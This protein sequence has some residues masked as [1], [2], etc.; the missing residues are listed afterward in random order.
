MRK[1]LIK[2]LGL[3]GSS[4]PCAAAAQAESNPTSMGIQHALILSIDGAHALDIA[5]YVR[6]NPQSA[7]AQLGAMGVNYTNASLPLGDFYPGVL[8]LVTGGTPNSTGVWYDGGFDRAL[9]AAGSDCTKVGA[10]F[11]YDENI[12]INVGQI[13]GDDASSRF[14][15]PFLGTLNHPHLLLRSERPEHRMGPP[16]GVL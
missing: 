7:F 2:C 9:S 11:M 3:L 14:R 4:M 13:D 8:S 5:N 6:T 15:P 10:E 1:T 12:D 16:P